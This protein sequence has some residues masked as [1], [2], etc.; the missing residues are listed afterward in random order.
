MDSLFSHPVLFPALFLIPSH[1]VTTTHFPEV[2][3]LIFTENERRQT[4]RQVMPSTYNKALTK[5]LNINWINMRLSF[6]QL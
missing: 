4:D 1:G 6:L 2:M 5:V 3:A